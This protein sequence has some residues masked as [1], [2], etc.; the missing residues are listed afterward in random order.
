MN[1]FK[2]PRLKKTFFNLSPLILALTVVNPFLSLKSISAFAS[3]NKPF[4]TSRP[5][6][7]IEY[8]RIM[9]TLIEEDL[10]ESPE[11][12]AKAIQIV[13][14]Q[15]AKIYTYKLNINDFPAFQE[16]YDT[17]KLLNEFV[18][19]IAH[20]EELIDAQNPSSAT[21]ST[22]NTLSKYQNANLNYFIESI[23][24]G[25]LNQLNV[26]PRNELEQ[27]LTSTRWMDLYGKDKN[28]T[29]EQIQ[30]KVIKIN[31]YLFQN[32]NL[33]PL[34]IEFM[35]NM[36]T[37]NI[38]SPIEFQILDQTRKMYFQKSLDLLRQK[39]LKSTA[40]NANH[41]YIA[42]RALDLVHP[43]K[44]NSKSDEE[45]DMNQ[46]HY[47]ENTDY[48]WIPN[49][50]YSQ[51]TLNTLDS[52]FDL[53]SSTNLEGCEKIVRKNIT[54]AN[55][56]IINDHFK[57]KIE[58]NRR[59]TLSA[60]PNSN[61]DLITISNNELTKS[62]CTLEILNN[63]TQKIVKTNILI[64]MNDLIYLQNKVQFKTNGLTANQFFNQRFLTS[65]QIGNCQLTADILLQSTK[66]KWIINGRIHYYD[67]YA[68]QQFI[69]V[70]FQ[71]SEKEDLNQFLTK[72]FQLKLKLKY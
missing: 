54:N 55:F 10:S 12:F 51:E 72:L 26:I 28:L 36:N 43:V 50:K 23:K 67:N 70:K 41:C 13:Q 11:N 20:E 21:S 65:S 1:P 63:F 32:I 6:V 64:T 5:E 58:S 29:P 53:L 3:Q 71:S 66:Q 31:Q 7:I 39:N 34:L 25:D 69:P 49:G 18:Q 47:P 22:A 57:Q 68:K 2:L 56:K 61:Y 17:Q 30:Q 59:S 45:F 4:Q 14:K 38:S 35:E 60:A 46:L 37:F 62:P 24:S 16:Y 42:N 9:E 8:S 40:K 48:N 15:D 27:Y 44:V 52:L 33:A 19:D